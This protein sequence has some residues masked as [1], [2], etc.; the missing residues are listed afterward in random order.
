M[1]RSPKIDPIQ[2]AAMKEWLA[3]NGVAES[4]LTYVPQQ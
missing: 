1:G 3:K 2:M 4:E